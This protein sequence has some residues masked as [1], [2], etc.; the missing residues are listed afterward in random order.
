VSIRMMHAVLVLSTL[1]MSACGHKEQQPPASPSAGSKKSIVELATMASPDRIIRDAQGNIIEIDLVGLS[2]S[3]QFVDSLLTQE[4]RSLQKLSVSGKMIT[5]Q[6]INAL[7]RSV[8]YPVFREIVFRDTNI[9][10][11]HI[12]VAQYREQ[13]QG[14]KLTFVTTSSEP[15]S[16]GDGDTRAALEK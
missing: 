13:R 12:W 11:G 2:L 16:A 4:L 5:P 1:M 8:P 7:M 14:T 9:P 15:P 3:D 10:E 6:T